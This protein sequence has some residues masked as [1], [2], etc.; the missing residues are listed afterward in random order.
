MLVRLAQ[1]K[2]PYPILFG[3]LSNGTLEETQLLGYYE[4][5]NQNSHNAMLYDSAL[6][7]SQF[8]NQELVLSVLTQTIICSVQVASLDEGKLWGYFGAYQFPLDLGYFKIKANGYGFVHGVSECGFIVT[9]AVS[10]GEV[11]PL[12]GW[13]EE[14]ARKPENPFVEY[15]R[16][17]LKQLGG[18]VRR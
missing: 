12:M 2:R 17:I 4:G 18:M 3:L 7:A 9:R 16:E 10:A 14:L 1:L 15:R 6:S 8:D 11:E 5:V 13:F